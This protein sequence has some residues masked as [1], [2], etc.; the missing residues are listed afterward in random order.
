MEGEGLVGRVPRRCRLETS[1]VRAVSELSLR[2]TTDDLKVL[3]SLEEDF[4]LF[5]R[6]LILEGD[7]HGKWLVIALMIRL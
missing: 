5:W 1:H 2:V 7:L 3:G 6:A 4:L